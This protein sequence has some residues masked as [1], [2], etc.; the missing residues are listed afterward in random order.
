MPSLKVHRSLTDADLL[1]QY[2]RTGDLSVLGELFDRYMSLVLG[3]CM[4]YLKDREESRDAVMQIFEK[5]VTTLK[6]HEVEHFKSWLYTTARN[7]CLMQLR[8]RKGK[9]FEEI[10]PALME[11]DSFSHLEE[12]PEMEANLTKLEKCIETLVVEQKQ[13]V[14]LF[15]LQQKCY[16]EIVQLTGFDDNKVKSYIQN[17]KRNLKICMEQHG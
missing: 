15:Y 12:E 3:V 14:Q 13:C 5:L 17:G 4:K 7:H 9:N 11:N 6:Q 1:A 8:S 10:S 16:K 2:K